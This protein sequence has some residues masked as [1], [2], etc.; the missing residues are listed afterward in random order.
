MR[1]EN[2]SRWPRLSGVQERRS[3]AHH[4]PM[5]SR[6]MV[7]HGKSMPS[8]AKLSPA[9][10]MVVSCKATSTALRA[11]RPHAPAPADWARSAS[12]PPCIAA[13]TH[14]ARQLDWTGSEVRHPRC[15][16]RCRKAKST[17][18]KG[19]CARWAHGIEITL[20]CVLSPVYVSDLTCMDLSSECVYSSTCPE[21]GLGLFIRL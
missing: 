13:Q 5:S 1:L 3:A 17:R 6:W 14:L 20:P 12:N 11:A 21:L 18:S 2:P 15:Q 4:N 8:L 9:V 16:R 10:P 7:F 19:C